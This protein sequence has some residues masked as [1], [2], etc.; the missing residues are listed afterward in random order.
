MLEDRASPCDHLHLP[1]PSRRPQDCCR[2][3]RDA[4]PAQ[5]VSGLT[6]PSTNALSSQPPRRRCRRR[7]S[8]PSCPPTATSSRRSATPGSFS[9][10]SRG[11]DARRTERRSCHSLRMSRSVSRDH[12]PRRRHVRAGARPSRARE[13]LGASRGGVGGRVLPRVSPPARL[14]RRLRSTFDPT[15]TSRPPTSASCCSS[16]PALPARTRP[17]STAS[18][19]SAAVSSISTRRRGAADQPR[20]HRRHDRIAAPLRSTDAA[21]EILTDRSAVI[22]ALRDVLGD[23]RRDALRLPGAGKGSR[24]HRVGT[25]R[26][27]RARAEARRERPAQLRGSGRERRWPARAWPPDALFSWPDL[28]TNPGLALATS[29]ARMRS[30]KAQDRHVACA[31]GRAAW[32]RR[33]LGGRDVSLATAA[34]RRRLFVADAPGAPSG[35]SSC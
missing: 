30:T 4:R 31:R 7:R 27:R 21:I 16:K 32:P 20:V 24:V 23:D 35:R 25:R 33:G 12:R 28:P 8:C 3:E 18:S 5:I 13:R 19:R 10:R 2:P 6:P 1:E 26:G 11:T 15:R 9:P 34:K 14:L 29:L 22:S 17:T